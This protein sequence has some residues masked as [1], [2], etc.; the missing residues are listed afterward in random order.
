MNSFLIL[1]RKKIKTKDWYIFVKNFLNQNFKT[2]CKYVVLH[3]GKIIWCVTYQFYLDT[4][5]ESTIYGFYECLWWWLI[6]NFKFKVSIQ[7]WMCQVSVGQG[8]P[9]VW[10]EASSDSS[11]EM[12]KWV[13]VF[14]LGPLI[15]TVFSAISH[16][17]HHQFLLLFKHLV[18][19]W[20]LPRTSLKTSAMLIMFNSQLSLYFL[21]YLFCLFIFGCI[22]PSLLC[23]GFL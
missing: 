10:G 2:V 8:C 19:S 21:I 7:E 11:R 5:S 23:A 17:Q 13:V 16:F 1:Y 22:G 9:A 18:P 3:S 4:A 12:V 6:R 15:W 14:A 20:L